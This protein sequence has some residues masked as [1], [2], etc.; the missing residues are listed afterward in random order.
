MFMSLKTD[1]DFE[2][3]SLI[4]KIFSSTEISPYKHKQALDSSKFTFVLPE[5]LYW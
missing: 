3:F 5:C 4:F 2:D 1:T